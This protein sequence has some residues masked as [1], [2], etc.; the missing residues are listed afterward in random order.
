MKY[1]HKAPQ[2]QRIPAGEPFA[3]SEW[4]E[5]A[6][7]IAFG[8]VLAL[9]GASYKKDDV[10]GWICVSMLRAWSVTDEDGNAVPITLETVKA[11]DPMLAA[12]LL[13]QATKLNKSFLVVQSGQTNQDASPSP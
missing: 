13:E 6:D 4:F 5:V 3:D 10:L 11:L 9:A 12:P 2:V 7:S 1:V 8:D